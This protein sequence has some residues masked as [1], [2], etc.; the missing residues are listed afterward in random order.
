MTQ[1]FTRMDQSTT[2]QWMEIGRQT[3]GNQP[4]VAEKVLGMLRE[5]QTITDGFAVDQLV[6]ALQTATRAER[7]GADEQVIVAALCHDIGKLISVANHPAIA[8]EILKPYVREEVYWMILVH[9]DFQGK[10]Y[11]ELLGKDPD[12]R[13]KYT[14][15]GS[16]ELAAK[17]ADDWDQTAFDPDYESFP[18]EHFEPMVR[19]V[20]AQPSSF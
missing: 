5:L 17:F 6:H 18:L 13:A 4:R 3:F 12:A 9:Q 14:G 20:F 16:F 1:S 7:G 15:H 8:A 2:E 11:Y 19:R 10:H